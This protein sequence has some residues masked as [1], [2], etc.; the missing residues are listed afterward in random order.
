M[1]RALPVTENL[2]KRNLWIDTS[3]VFCNEHDESIN[4][5]LFQCRFSKKIWE[6]SPTRDDTNRQLGMDDELKD[7][8]AALL[9]N[10]PREEE[11]ALLSFY[12]G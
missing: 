12:L 10:A 4:Q 11:S 7:N 3:C 9:P 8:V 2:R 6:L 5:L 1:H